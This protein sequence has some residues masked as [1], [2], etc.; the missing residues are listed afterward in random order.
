MILPKPYL[1]DHHIHQR[2]HTTERSIFTA[3]TPFSLI[4]KSLVLFQEE[5]TYKQ[6]AHGTDCSVEHSLYRVRHTSHVK[7]M[8]QIEL[9]AHG[10]IEFPPYKLLLLPRGWGIKQR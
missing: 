10:F 6:V 7:R 2:E 8:A 3:Q 4:S 1:Q 9:I 5:V